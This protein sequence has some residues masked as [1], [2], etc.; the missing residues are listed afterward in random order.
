VP[1]IVNN[2]GR[3]RMARADTQY[4]EALDNFIK[5]MERVSSDPNKINGRHK[6]GL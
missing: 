1:V 5:A 2:R 6:E 4:S 3:S